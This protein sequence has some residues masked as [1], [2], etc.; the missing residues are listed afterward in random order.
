MDCLRWTND[1]M[2]TAIPKRTRPQTPPNLTS[3]LPQ[4]LKSRPF[5]GVASSIQIT[6]N[7]EER[8][9]KTFET[10]RAT[11]PLIPLTAKS[12]TVAVRLMSMALTGFFMT[13]RRPRTHRPLSM[14][15]YDPVGE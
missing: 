9:D 4:P 15:K 8:Y 10:T 3:V 13:F 2:S 7:G 12:R 5:S 14:L 1:P 6:Q 11:Y